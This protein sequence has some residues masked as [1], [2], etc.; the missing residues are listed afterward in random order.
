[1]TTF[2]SGGLSVRQADRQ[3]CRS[4]RQQKNR[5]WKITAEGPKI[6]SQCGVLPSPSSALRHGPVCFSYSL[7]P[8]YHHM[9]R[10]AS[11]PVHL[12]KHNLYVL[13]FFPSSLNIRSTYLVMF[14]SFLC[15]LC[16]FVKTVNSWQGGVI[17]LNGVS[18][19]QRSTRHTDHVRTH[20]IA[21]TERDESFIVFWSANYTPSSILTLSLSVFHCLFFSSSLSSACLSSRVLHPDQSG[22]LSRLLW[23]LHH[24]YGVVGTGEIRDE[25]KGRVEKSDRWN[26]GQWRCA[27]GSFSLCFS[28]SLSLPGPQLKRLKETGGESASHPHLPLFCLAQTDRSSDRVI[29]LKTTLMTDAAGPDTNR[30]WQECLFS[31]Q[32]RQKLPSTQA[33]HDQFLHFVNISLTTA[34]KVTRSQP[35]IEEDQVGFGSVHQGLPL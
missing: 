19:P 20:L 28:L 8:S 1:M 11:T 14:K 10:A 6:P 13:L 22:I 32:R 26:V 7:P 31:A 29:S 9:D 4:G 18:S 17:L 23:S 3:R 34:P 2:K 5:R 21:L 30:V 15:Y 33:W 12:I 24:N 27:R 35:R 16:G 25:K